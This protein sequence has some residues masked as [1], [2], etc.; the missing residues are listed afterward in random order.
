[1]KIS[2][3]KTK[4][5]LTFLFSDN[6]LG[7]AK[8]T[9]D[10]DKLA[11]YQDFP[12]PPNLLLKNEIKNDQ[13]F[14]KFIIG[15][16][17]QL[18]IEK[19]EIIVGLSEDKS[20]SYT[21]TLPP[22]EPHEINQAIAYKTASFL[23]FAYKNEYLD[24][25]LI[26]TLPDKNKRV[27]LC[28]IPKEIIDKFTTCLLSANLHPV[29]FETTSLS[30]FRLI[31]DE[32]KKFCFTSSLSGNIATSVFCKD[33]SLIACAVSE[34]QE[35]FIKSLQNMLK[36]YCPEDC[37]KPPYKLYLTGKG[38]TDNFAQAVK[39]LGFDAIK[40]PLE[41][42]SLIYSLCHKDILPP[43]DENSI[44]ILPT[45]LLTDDKNIVKERGKKNLIFI[46]LAILI[47]FNLILGFANYFLVVKRPGI[48]R[49]PQ[50]N[51]IEKAKS[52]QNKT[53]TAWQIINDEKITANI[54]AFVVNNKLVKIQGINFSLEKREIVITGIADTRVNLLKFK[55]EL[56]KNKIFTRVSLPLSVLG[57]EN[58]IDFNISLKF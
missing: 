12:L 44:N 56:E 23:P 39:P 45:S 26:E 43:E 18:N 37:P 11:F 51:L 33:K 35:E 7:V 42:F 27:L 6:L 13:E 10:G 17:T 34:G 21:I 54:L 9:P 22:L 41:D 8:L 14:I 47:I 28:A 16:K 30:L 55:D 15:I 40:F 24:W 2:T 36:Y 1:M 20:F 49:S 5:Y 32:D 38:D 29:A 52:Y 48:S 53:N 19:E 46:T 31:P 50:K 4:P 25:M 58:N 3:T 57:S